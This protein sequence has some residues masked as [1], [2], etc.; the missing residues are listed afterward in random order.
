MRNIDPHELHKFDTLASSW[1]DKHGPIKTLHDIN[2]LRLEFIQ[3]QASLNEKK[4]LDVGCGGGI[5]AESLAKAGANVTAIDATVSLINIAKLHA[6]ESKLSIDYRSVTAEELA[7]EKPLFDVV[8]CME[9]L[10]HVPN[11][12]GLIHCLS[13][14]LKP[15]GQLFVSTINRTLKAYL[16]AIITAEH[17]LKLLPKGTHD[18]AKLIKPSELR[19]WCESAG[20]GLETMKGMRYQPFMKQYSLTDDVSINYLLYAKKNDA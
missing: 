17:V 8:T 19:Q 7:T 2:P 5:L 9:L 16:L 4:I 10:E 18:Y 14:M 20:L 12:A 15:G 1:W 11:P 13:S 6:L 3:N